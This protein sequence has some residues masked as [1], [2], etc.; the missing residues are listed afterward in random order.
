MFGIVFEF[1]IDDVGVFWF[2]WFVFE[3]MVVY[4]VVLDWL[5]VGFGCGE[6]GFFCFV[7][8]VCCYGKVDGYGIIVVVVYVEFGWV[9][10]CGF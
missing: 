8:F 1:V 10:V 5:V 7:G 3:G 9:F 4:V 2:V 6:F